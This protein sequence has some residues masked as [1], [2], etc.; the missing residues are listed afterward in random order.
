M[1]TMSHRNGYSVRLSPMKAIAD[2][3]QIFGGMEHILISVE[4]AHQLRIVA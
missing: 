4:M 1:D 2:M 3:E